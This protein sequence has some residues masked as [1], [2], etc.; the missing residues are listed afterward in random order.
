M[1]KSRRMRL[2]GNVAR[3][4]DMRNARNVMVGKP[5]RKRPVGRPGRRWEDNIR[6]D[7]REID[8]KCVD[9]MHLTQDR[10]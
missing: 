5:G 1:I 4:G 2:A 7:R 3:M 6:M 10:N 8:W 9:W